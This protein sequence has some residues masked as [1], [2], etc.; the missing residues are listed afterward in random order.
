MSS[1]TSPKD[2]NKSSSNENFTATDTG[3]TGAE[4]AQTVLDTGSTPDSCRET[5]RINQEEQAF[6]HHLTLGLQE[7][8]RKKR[9]WNGTSYE[10][11]KF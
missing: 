3:G 5:L 9:I 8:L 4:N 6:H 2:R 7:K 1:I 10:I 11:L